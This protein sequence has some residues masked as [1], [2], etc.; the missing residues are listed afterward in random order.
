MGV[1]HMPFLEMLI[2]Y[3]KTTCRSNDVKSLFCRKIQSRVT[4]NKNIHETLHQ[5]ACFDMFIF[6]PKTRSRESVRF[7]IG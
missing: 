7:I 6:S 3:K 2:Q 4:D 5:S 1:Q